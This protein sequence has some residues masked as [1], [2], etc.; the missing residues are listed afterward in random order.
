M[1]KPNI[2]ILTVPHGASHQGA[3]GGLARAL[4]EIE[5]GATVEVV[6]ALR[7]CAPWFRAYYNSYEIPLKYWPGLW[8]WIES[9]QHQA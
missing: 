7:H 8:S 3:A 5:P 2:L 4:V 9:V 1:G 6:D